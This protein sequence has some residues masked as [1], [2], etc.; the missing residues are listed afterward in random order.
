MLRRTRVSDESTPLSRPLEVAPLQTRI[1]QSVAEK[2][3]NP[4]LLGTRFGNRP[5]RIRPL[6]GLECA[7]KRGA[8][9]RERGSFCSHRSLGAR[10]R[11]TFVPRA[12]SADASLLLQYR[13]FD[14]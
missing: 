12:A 14:S 6:G 4:S 8:R 5:P 7:C 10:R 2:L 3:A 13:T 11:G 1:R 9:G